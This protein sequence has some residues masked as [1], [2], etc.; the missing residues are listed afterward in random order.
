MQSIRFPEATNHAES[1]VFDTS[2]ASSIALFGELC[3]GSYPHEGVPPA[4]H[5]RPVQTG[6]AWLRKARGT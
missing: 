3:G 2:D 4:P 5:V 1:Q 6:A